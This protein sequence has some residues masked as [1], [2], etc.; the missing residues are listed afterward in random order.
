MNLGES[1]F[2]DD[3]YAR[4]SAI[5][6]LMSLVLFLIPCCG[7]VFAIIAVICG[8]I[9]FV[10]QNKVGVTDRDK[11]LA[12]A[13]IICGALGLLITITMYISN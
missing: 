10:R 7:G 2:G 3:P 1:P 8:I 13:G 6:G 11:L 5:V 9:F 4:T 12:I